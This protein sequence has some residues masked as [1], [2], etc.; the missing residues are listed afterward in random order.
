MDKEGRQTD[1][2][3]DG[4]RDRRTARQRDRQIDGFQNEVVE[5]ASMRSNA[6]TR[7]VDVNPVMTTST[8]RKR[9]YKHSKM[10]ENTSDIDKG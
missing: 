3:T 7:D 6:S 2:Q 9:S 1:R 8:R 4:Q 5:L 10:A